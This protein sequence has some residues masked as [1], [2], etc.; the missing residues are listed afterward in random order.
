MNGYKSAPRV[1]AERVAPLFALNGWTWGGF[2]NTPEHV[3][4]VDEIEQEFDRL[5]EWM[6]EI[7]SSEV[8][9]GRLRVKRGDREQGT[10]D[11]YLLDLVEVNSYSGEPM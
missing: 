6:Y 3:P 8:A 5:T 11:Q 10:G 2:G 9:T 4:D 1:A 7:K